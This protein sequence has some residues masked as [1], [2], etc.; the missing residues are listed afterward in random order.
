[1][2]LHAA[3]MRAEWEK[4][5]HTGKLMMSRCAHGEV[6][7][8]PGVGSGHH[9]LGIEHLLS[10]LRDGNGVVL[11]AS[12]GGQGDVAG[13]EEVEA[14][15]GDR[16]DGQLPQVRVELTWEAQ[17]G[18]NTGHEDRHEVAEIAISWGRQV[19]GYGSRYRTGP[20]WLSI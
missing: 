17:A 20:R 4:M 8:M 11:L 16:V 15:E 14:W 10:E 3:I 6:A 9:V 13:H 1:M 19:E 2:W 12:A 7:T 18:R 5:E